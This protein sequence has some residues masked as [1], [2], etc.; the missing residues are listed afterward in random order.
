MPKEMKIIYSLVVL[1]SFTIGMIVMLI[2]YKGNIEDIASNYVLVLGV[3]VAT[4]V[5]IYFLL[6]LFFHLNANEEKDELHLEDLPKDA[7]DIKNEH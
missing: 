1:V 5:F 7:D 3:Y 2:I 4:L 6:K